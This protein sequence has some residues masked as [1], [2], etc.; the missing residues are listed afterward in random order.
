MTGILFQMTSNQ[1]ESLSVPIKGASDVDSVLLKIS[2]ERP[3]ETYIL[4]K[5][6]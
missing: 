1:L 2:Q 6:T 5:C 4:P 3:R